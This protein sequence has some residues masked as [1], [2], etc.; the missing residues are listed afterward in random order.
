M[1]PDVVHHRYFRRLSA[2]V[3]NTTVECR[4]NDVLHTTRVTNLGVPVYRSAETILLEED[5]RSFRVE[6][7]EGFFPF[8]RRADWIGRG[9]PRRTTTGPRTSSPASGWRWSR[10]RA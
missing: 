4:E 9:R 2:L 3:L 1:L 10:R 8:L 7:R 5:G 6:G